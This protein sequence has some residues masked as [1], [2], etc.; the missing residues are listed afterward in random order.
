MS[1]PSS[2]PLPFQ[3]TVL[4]DQLWPLNSQPFEDGASV[5]E[6]SIAGAAGFSVFFWMIQTKSGSFRCSEAMIS[7]YGIRTPVLQRRWNDFHGVT[8]NGVGL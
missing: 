6:F 1:F 5:A 8:T 3:E 4:K 2:Y 7:G